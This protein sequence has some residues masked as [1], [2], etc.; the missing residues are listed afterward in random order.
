MNAIREEFPD[1]VILPAIG[2]NDVIVHNNVPCTSEWKAKYFS[3]LFDVWFPE[4][5]VP[6]SFNRA[7][8]SLTFSK[9]G[10]YR[11]DFK[12]SD[13]T[14]LV[15]NTMF[16]KKDNECS[17][18]DG[19]AQ[20][21]W[22]EAQLEAIEDRKVLLSMHVFPGVNYFMKNN[23]VF[24]HEDAT[25]RFLEILSRHQSSIELMTGAHIHKSEYRNS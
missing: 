19:F 4:N 17:L 8:A 7:E 14:L 13:R 12:H 21:D 18:G 23:Q 6:E 22:L 16:F 1:T 10:Y 15:L 3:E 9:G 24:W 11:H 2:N 5:R 20:L 25:E